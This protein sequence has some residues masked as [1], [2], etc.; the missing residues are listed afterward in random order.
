[1]LASNAWPSLTTLFEGL[2][3]I[4]RANNVIFAILQRRERKGSYF[5]TEIRAGLAAFFA[6]AYIIA[7]NASIVADTGGTC[8]C[9]S[10]PA[11][12]ICKTNEAYALCSAE[13]KRDLV[14]ATAAIAALSSFCMGL[15]ANLCV[16]S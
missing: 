16:L 9:D 6:M 8:I 12:P 13:V 14:T 5:F 7:V 3:G 4:R 10:T 1:M 11:D 15:F 2:G